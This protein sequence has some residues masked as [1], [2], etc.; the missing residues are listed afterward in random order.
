MICTHAYYNYREHRK[1]AYYAQKSEVMA[2]IEEIYHSHNGVDGY[3]NMTVY[4][5]RKGCRYSPLTVHKY[6]NT[7]M[8]LHSIV[9]P[10]KPGYKHGKPHKVFENGLKQDFHADGKNQK[11][12][13]DFT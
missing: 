3:R 1:A 10:K 11:W 13:T 12:C 7:K 9:R 4:L 2:Q 5:A 6:M 8:G